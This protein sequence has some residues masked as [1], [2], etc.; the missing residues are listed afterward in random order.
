[1]S[2]PSTKGGAWV[3]PDDAPDWT[4]EVFDMAEVR[5]GEELLRSAKGALGRGRPRLERPKVRVTLRLDAD[6]VDKLREAGPG[7]QTR[8][9]DL[10]K[11][12]AGA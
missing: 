1:M 3:D 5:Q 8:A 4:P 2:E 11:K 10:L 12:A 7:C 9:N 6:L